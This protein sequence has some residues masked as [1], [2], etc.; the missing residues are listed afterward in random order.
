MTAEAKTN[1][2]SDM[3]KTSSG[4]VKVQSFI[5]R[6]QRVL[7]AVANRQMREKQVGA[8]GMRS[9]GN[10]FMKRSASVN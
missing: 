3:S 4:F 8:A 2:K 5:S 9:G 10:E 6:P 7:T 1:V